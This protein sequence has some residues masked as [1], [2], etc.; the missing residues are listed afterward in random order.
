[1]SSQV[2]SVKQQRLFFALWPDDAL[3]E[4]LENVVKT[5]S[6]PEGG[7][8][9][10]VENLHITL[11]F[12]GYMQA[13]KRQCAEQVADRMVHH[14]P[15]QLVL[16]RL[17]HFPRPRVLWLGAS[18][19]PEPLTILARDF[20][21]EL[22]TCGLQPEQRPFHAH[23]TLMRKVNRTPTLPPIDPIEWPIS[24]FALVESQTLPEGA[25]YE[26]LRFW[27]LT[28]TSIS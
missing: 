26:V 5:I 27:S 20:N 12:L 3:R 21:Q 16:D 6:K 13:E 9:V 17:G 25:K 4:Q 1:M 28:G 14:P 7:R 2:T 10:P 8:L 24:Q 18:Q 19:T 11:R 22:K 23:M 15:C